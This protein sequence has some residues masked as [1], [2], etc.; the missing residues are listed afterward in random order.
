M[1]T[2]GIQ[3]GEKDTEYVAKAFCQEA[4][5]ISLKLPKFKSCQILKNLQACLVYLKLFSLHL[6][7]IVNNRT[8][9][10]ILSIQLRFFRMD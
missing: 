8:Q 9:S 2:L 5:G 3:Y 7:V 10:Y 4:E 1:D 6:S